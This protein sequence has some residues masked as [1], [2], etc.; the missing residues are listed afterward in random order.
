MNS[1]IEKEKKLTIALTKLKNLN[2]KNIIM[3]KNTFNLEVGFSDHTIGVGACLASIAL[4]AT[5]IEKHFT[6]D[7]ERE[8]PAHP[9]SIASSANWSPTKAQARDAPPSITRT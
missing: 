4:G 2:L 8:G 5:V 9:F 3:L 6:D 1:L 7:T